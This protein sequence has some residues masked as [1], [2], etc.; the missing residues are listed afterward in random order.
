MPSTSEAP[1]RISSSA[2]ARLRFL[3]DLRAELAV[4]VCEIAGTEIVELR[5]NG[6]SLGQRV[7][8]LLGLGRAGCSST[9]LGC[10]HVIICS[11]RH[12]NT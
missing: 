1:R 5:Y 7:T 2:T 4:L 3:G 6:D 9:S 11:L 8:P 12:V 10:I